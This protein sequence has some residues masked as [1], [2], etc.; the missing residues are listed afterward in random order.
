MQQLSK[1]ATDVYGTVAE[2]RS[3]AGGLLF[4]GFLHVVLA[5]VLSLIALSNLNSAP[6]EPLSAV[7]DGEGDSGEPLTI[8]EELN[9]AE[10]SGP[11]KTT[12]SD[13]ASVDTALEVSASVQP[14]N[15][16]WAKFGSSEASQASG[17]GAIEANIQ[18]RV[19]K[20]GGRSGEVQFSLSWHSTNDVDLH[21]IAPSGEHISYQHRRSVCTGELDV[22]MNV[23]PESTEPV[24]NVRWLKGTAPNG[25]YT[26]LIHQFRW[27]AGQPDDSI[28]LLV[29]LGDETTIIEQ[30][31]S[32]TSPLAIQRFQY[33][34]PGFSA[35][36]KAALLNQL[37]SLQRRE[38]SKASGLLE[39][40]ISMPPSPQRDNVL[41]RIINQYAHTDASIQAMQELK[42]DSNKR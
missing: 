3:A 4:S 29:K 33:V 1:S 5:V 36:R 42:G 34:K 18:G 9:A 28:E 30:K 22:D 23:Q 20:A 11:L 8:L 41:Q 26:I 24:E 39:T 10:I 15:V 35:S 38:E 13:A 19:G 37:T 25:R 14:A 7:F 6:L 21:V 27:R 40:A 12:L 31:L 17:L 32:A 16:D 2:K